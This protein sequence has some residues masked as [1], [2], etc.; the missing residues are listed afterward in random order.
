[1]EDNITLLVKIDEM[2]VQRILE[3]QPKVFL[4]KTLG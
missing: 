4:Q 3:F 1:M 2:L